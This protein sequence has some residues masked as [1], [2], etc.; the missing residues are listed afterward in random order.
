MK[1]EFVSVVSHELKTPLTSIG[2]YLS[3]MKKGELGKTTFQQDDA[4]EIMKEESNR[5]T[6]MVNEILDLSRLES[7]KAT[8]NAQMTNIFDLLQDNSNYLL[9]EK[10][11]IRVVMDVPPAFMAKVDIA[12][13]QRIFINLLSNAVKYTAPGGKI[14]ITVQDQARRWL[15]SVTDTGE[16]IPK[17]KISKL[18]N[19]FYQVDDYMTRKHGGSGLGLSIV[20]E[21]V[22][23]HKGKITVNSTLGKGSSFTVY[24]PKAA[25]VR[26]RR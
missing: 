23:L 12:K 4:L 19:K 15:F 16:G 3:L 26:I 14:T 17:D 18:F 2:L 21:L 20:Y 8:F 24:F 6:T 1:D 22:K 13:F 7:K 9:A 5:L 11:K 25:A 10:K